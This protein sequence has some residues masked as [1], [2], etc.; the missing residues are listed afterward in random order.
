MDKDKLLDKIV[1]EVSYKTKRGYPVWTE[2]E[3]LYALSKVLKK[4]GLTEIRDELIY[5]LI[6]EDEVDIKT[7]DERPET[8]DGYVEI[9]GHP[10]MFIK[11]GDMRDDGSYDSENVQRY[12]MDGGSLKPVDDDEEE[13]ER[14]EDK[15]E[16]PTDAED[17][18]EGESEPTGP[19]Q[20]FQTP[21]YQQQLDAE[22]EYQDDIEKDEEN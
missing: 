1:R 11:Q 15:G 18:E 10:P 2:D 5:N 9:G 19:K 21:D 3:T 14:E 4:Y 12:V 6:G 16:E 7:K 20:I 13:D 22:K 17:G 8:P